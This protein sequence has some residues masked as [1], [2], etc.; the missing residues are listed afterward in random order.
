MPYSVW[1]AITQLPETEWLRNNTNLFLMLLSGGW[2]SEI[3]ERKDSV[4][5]KGALS[6]L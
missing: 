3:K 1:V 4:T 6:R 2:K 5:G